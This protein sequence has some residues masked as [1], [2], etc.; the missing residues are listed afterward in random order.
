MQRFYE[1]H[2][3][4]AYKNLYIACMSHK[5]LKVKTFAWCTANETFFLVSIS[6]SRPCHTLFYSFYCQYHLI[7][8]RST[9]RDVANIHIMFC[10]NYRGKPKEK[11]VKF[12]RLNAP[13]SVMLKTRKSKTIH[14]SLKPTV[15]KVL[16]SSVVY[17][18]DRL[19]FVAS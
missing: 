15:L 17:K 4:F 7:W 9:S 5:L 14:P 16:R 11:L 1:L 6:T 12:L 18:I 10:I 8:S 13:C 2:Q 19:G 3:A